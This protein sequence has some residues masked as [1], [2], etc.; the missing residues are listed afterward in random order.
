MEFLFLGTSAGTPTRTRNV[1]GLALRKKNQRAW[2]LVD[3]GEGTQH[4]VLKTALSLNSLST[5]CITH[6]HGD[7]CYGL[8]GILASAGMGKRQAPLTVIAPRAIQEWFETTRQLTDLYLSYPVEFVAVEDMQ[9]AW[10][11][12]D[13]VISTHPLSHRVPCYAYQ[14]TERPTNTRRLN[15][16][17]LTEAQIP[18]AP[19]WRQLQQGENPQLPDGRTL[20]ADDYCLASPPARQVVVAGDNDTPALLQAACQDAQLLIHEATY[21]AEVS[22]KVGEFP[23]HSDAARIAA[24]AES[25]AL[26]H[27]IL[28]HFSSRYAPEG[29][30][31]PSLDDLANEAAMHYHGTLFLAHDFDQFSLDSAGAVTRSDTLPTTLP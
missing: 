10:V 25:V 31:S 6:V 4:Q 15:V 24:F 13:F 27:L 9:E 29:C 3:C 16:A 7:H 28:T 19:Y 17:K 12:E 21:T 8:P 30:P 20:L 22:A 11:T 26:P 5:I 2:V 23:Q 1:T 14:F 18:S